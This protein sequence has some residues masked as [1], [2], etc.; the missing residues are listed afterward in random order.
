M[1]NLNGTLW[2]YFTKYI[3]KIPCKYIKASVVDKFLYLLISSNSEFPPIQ[4]FQD[5][6]SGIVGDLGVRQ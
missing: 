4:L 1:M 6:N 5:L 2:V 3:N